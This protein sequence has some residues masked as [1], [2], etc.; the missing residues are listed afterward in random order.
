MTWLR[1]PNPTKGCEANERR[2]TTAKLH[3]LHNLKDTALN[4]GPLDGLRHT[5]VFHQVPVFIY[6]KYQHS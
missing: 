5:V 3:V 4:H 2:M 1:K 6:V